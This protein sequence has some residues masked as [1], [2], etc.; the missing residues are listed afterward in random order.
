MDPPP[1][2][3]PALAVQL[4][5]L[6]TNASTD[7]QDGMDRKQQTAAV[8]SGMKPLV[9][10]IQDQFGISDGQFCQFGASYTPVSEWF[11][12][13]FHCNQGPNDSR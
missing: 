4:N 3:I 1:E 2:E 13:H 11:H 6:A 5:K 12:H 8:D 10:K 9:T 7:T